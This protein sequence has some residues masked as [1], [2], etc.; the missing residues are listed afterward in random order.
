MA[1]FSTRNLDRMLGVIAP[2]I[3]E[4]EVKWL[5]RRLRDGGNHG[6]G[7]EW[8]IAVL[9]GLSQAGTIAAIPDRAGVGKLDVLFAP[10]EEP[11]AI[12][13]VE[14]SAISD[15][16]RADRLTQSKSLAHRLRSKDDQRRR[17]G[18]KHPVI[19]VLADNDC[20]ALRRSRHTPTPS[21]D[22]L[23][24]EVLAGRREWREGVWLLQREVRPWAPGVSGVLLLAVHDAWT[25][26]GGLGVRLSP[27][28]I[29]SRRLP[30]VHPSVIH[31]LERALHALPP[32]R[33]SPMR[34][35]TRQSDDHHDHYGG[36][37]VEVGK[38]KTRFHLSL[39][40]VRAVMD[41]RIPVERFMKDHHDMTR[42]IWL[43]VEQ[44]RYL[45]AA[46]VEPTPD[47]DDDW[48]V[49]EFRTREV[50]EPV[51]SSVDLDRADGLRSG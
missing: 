43:A 47:V 7:A 24:D 29:H 27:T 22:D 2:V 41:G 31:A 15:A 34:A 6:V 37:Q 48:L 20:F 21:G 10:Q 4:S 39:A 1:I 51:S 3:G 5:R 44:G 11:G 18:L 30:A 42:Y 50:T 28:Y 8:E 26:A 14:V 49:L 32:F 33:Q 36:G 35:R 9:Y 17:S 23:V 19:V 45:T 46:Y 25:S 16:H 38:T 13:Q 40:G 12:V